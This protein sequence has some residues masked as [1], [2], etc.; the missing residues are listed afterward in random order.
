MHK[1]TYILEMF[2]AR[3]NVQIFDL[4]YNLDTSNLIW[5]VGGIELLRNPLIVWIVIALLLLNC[6]T[7][8]AHTR[9]ANTRGVYRWRWLGG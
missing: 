4:V 9:Y 3:R 6:Q 2:L 7:R 8:N 1:T 5:W